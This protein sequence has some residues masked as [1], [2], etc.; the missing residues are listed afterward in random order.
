MWIA[1]FPMAAG[2]FVGSAILMLLARQPPRLDNPG[3]YLRICL[4]GLLWSV[5]NYGM[6]LLVG[7]KCRGLHGK[8]H[9]S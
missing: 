3:H 1:A 4:T 7:R 6:L 8:C 2:M 5:G 9:G